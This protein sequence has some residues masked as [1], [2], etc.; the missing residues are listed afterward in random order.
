MVNY[1][2]SSGA[3]DSPDLGEIRIDILRVNVD[4]AS[5]GPDQID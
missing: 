1:V 4:K 2:A 5:E 3:Q